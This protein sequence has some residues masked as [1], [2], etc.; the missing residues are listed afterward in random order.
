LSAQHLSK[1]YC[2][3][4]LFSRRTIREVEALADVSLTIPAG[5][6]IG[7][8]GES[9][10][11][12][13]TLARCLAGLERPD[14]GHVWFHGRDLFGLPA[15]ELRSCRRAVQM[16][17]QDSAMA[18]N[19][20][21]DLV[22]IVAEPMAI[23]GAARRQ[24][25]ASATELLEHVG[26]PA[27]WAARKPE[28]L[29]G[30]QRQRVAIAR[31]LAADPE[32]LILDE[33]LSGLDLRTQVQIIELLVRLQAERR[34]SCLFISHDLRLAGQLTSEIAVMHRGRIVESG[35][36]A[37]VLAHPAHAYTQSLIAATPRRPPSAGSL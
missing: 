10:S 27:S 22:K 9:G 13:S 20:G 3:T 29:S 11:G 36:T 37:S 14:E 21:F 12:K 30:G 26:L 33:S 17:F 1:R 16:V 2:Q 15:R 19:P 34:F 18:L 8:A 32:V 23:A 24:R 4:Q 35:P 7:V 6:R 25:Q 31:A 28:Q 5:S